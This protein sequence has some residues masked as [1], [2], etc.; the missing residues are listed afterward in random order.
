MNNRRGY[1]VNVGINNPAY[2]DGRTMKLKYCEC[3]REL[4]SYNTKKCKKCYLKTLKGKSNPSYKGKIKINC[5]T[6]NKMIEIYPYK[7][8]NKHHYCNQLC[9]LNSPYNAF[10]LKGKNHHSFKNGK[11][12][13]KCGKLLKHYNT[14][15][16][17]SC[18]ERFN[19]LG[20]KNP[21]YINGKGKEPYSSK[22]TNELKKQIR[23]RD[24]YTCQKCYKKEQKYFRK[25]SVHH[26][27]YNKKNCNEKNLITLCHKCHNK[28]NFNRDY[29]FAY[30]VYIM[31]NYK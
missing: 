13:C 4:S 24:D 17:K 5:S 21:A 18:S 14:K 28:T 8:K 6:C 27:D 16:C 26:I 22:W 30:F 29:W 10:R 25:L 7:I 23:K 3:G 31:E 9:R 1:H 11:P 12:H 15:R 2:K 19:K 20:K